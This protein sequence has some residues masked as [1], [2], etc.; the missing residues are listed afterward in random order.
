MK[1]NFTIY[2]YSNNIEFVSGNKNAVLE[3]S[4]G[5][6]YLD[7]FHPSKTVNVSNAKQSQAIWP[8][9][10]QKG[11]LSAAGLHSLD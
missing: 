10:W 2:L 6:S 4:I 9:T 1:S 5:R 3:Q 7:T 8:K 11:G